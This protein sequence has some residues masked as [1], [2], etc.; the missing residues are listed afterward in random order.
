MERCKRKAQDDERPLRQIFDDVC[1]ST[2]DA[3]PLLSFAELESAMYKRRRLS[4][5]TLPTSP[6]SADNVIVSSRYAH[7]DGDE[8]YRGTAE[9]GAD[10]SAIIF[11]TDKQLQLLQSAC[12]VY[13]DATFKVVPSIYYQLFTIFVPFADAAFPVI[14]ALMTRKTQA[15]YIAVFE[16]VKVLTPQFTPA[17]AMADFEEASVSAFKHVYGSVNISGC[18]FHYA[19]AIVKR[20]NKVGLKNAYQQNADVMDTVRC[21]LGLPLLPALEITAAVDDVLQAINASCLFAH[22]LRQLVEYVQS[23]WIRK[24][25]I[26]PERLT[27]RHHK[28]RTNN[29]L[30]SYHSGLRRRI[31]VTHPNLFSFLGHLQRL[32]TDAMNDLTR[33]TNGHNIRRP[34]KKLNLLNETRIKACIAR[35]DVGSYNRLQFLRAISHCMG[36]HTNAFHPSTEPSDSEDVDEHQPSESQAAISTP[37]SSTPTSPST[38]PVAV[39]APSATVPDTCCEVCLVAPR[40]TVALVP[41]GHSRFCSSCVDTLSAMGSSC[42]ICRTPI[43]TVLR[44]FN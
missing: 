39:V 28:S 12:E 43:Q 11:A 8:F 37:T 20:I 24:S 35:F 36:A 6:L 7:L 1:R 41:C 32:T 42:P 16:K 40:A 30:E 14:F 26:G 27:V 44:L 38:Q 17:S 29:V 25:S 15:L 23:Q 22:Q 31:Q 3:A 10:G 2:P 9:A 19:Q 34:K 21:M 18:W 13:F 5:P 33:L 4:Q